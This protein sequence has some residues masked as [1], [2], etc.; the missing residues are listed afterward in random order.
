MQGSKWEGNWEG[1]VNGGMIPNPM[2]LKQLTV[3]KGRRHLLA[4]LFHDL[5]SSRNKT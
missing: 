2:V 3:A 4:Q 1:W 5:Y